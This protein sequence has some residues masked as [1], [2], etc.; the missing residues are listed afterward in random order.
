MTSRIPRRLGA[1]AVGAL[2]AALL[3]GCGVSDAQF[4]P[5]AAARVGDQTVSINDVDEIVD[6]ACLYFADQAGAQPAPGQPAA[7]A[8][9][10]GDVRGQIVQLL[11]QRAASEQLLDEYDADL[12]PAYGQAVAQNEK[13]YADLPADQRDPLVTGNEAGIYYQAALLGVGT[14]ILEDEGTAAAD[15]QAAAERGLQAFQEWVE[16]NDV[17]INPIFDVS[18]T[19]G[20]FVAEYA[21]PVSVP[22]SD[23]AKLALVEPQAQGDQVRE[24]YAAV[25]PADQRCG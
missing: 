3:S 12:A 21:T 9:P 6:G 13:Q 14:K 7:R 1:L 5:G 15:Q 8:V 18:V 24:D 25:L 20:A 17:A 16:S 19:D 22:V 11:A 2:S 23:L 4:D 10:R